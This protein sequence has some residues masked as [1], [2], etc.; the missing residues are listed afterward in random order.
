MPGRLETMESWSETGLCSIDAAEVSVAGQMAKCYRLQQ[1]A[2]DC[3]GK[4][5]VQLAVG[6]WQS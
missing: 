5:K 6:W 4:D 3:R 2:G 1:Q